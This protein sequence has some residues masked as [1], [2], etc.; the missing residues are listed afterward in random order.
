MARTVRPCWTEAQEDVGRTKTGRKAPGWDQACRGTPF[1]VTSTRRLEV[2]ESRSLTAKSLAE[3]R[4]L[5]DDEPLTADEAA[6]GL[7]VRRGRRGPAWLVYKNS[8]AA[9]HTRIAGATTSSGQK[10]VLRPCCPFRDG[11]QDRGMVDVR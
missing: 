5:T 1:A 10:Y 2:R 11:M 9:R 4:P 8:A 3:T 6:D 7:V